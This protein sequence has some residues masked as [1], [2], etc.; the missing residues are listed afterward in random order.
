MFSPSDQAQ[1]CQS[2]TE[3]PDGCG[4]G[5]DRRYNNIVNYDDA[6][7]EWRSNK[8]NR[9]KIVPGLVEQNVYYVRFSPEAQVFYQPVYGSATI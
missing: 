1:T 9:S 4:D 8:L 5:D 2:R 3:Q 7:F 6:V